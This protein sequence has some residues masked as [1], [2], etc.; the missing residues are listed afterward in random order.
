[1]ELEPLLVSK[2]TGAGVL[3][4]SLRKIDYMIASG[5]LPVRRIGRRVL[6]PLRALRQFAEKPIKSQKASAKAR[7]HDE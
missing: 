2:K 7:G 3:G 4:V 5:I 6:L 1:M